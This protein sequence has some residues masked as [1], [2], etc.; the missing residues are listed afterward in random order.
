MCG[1]DSSVA[2]NRENV[3]TGQTFFCFPKISSKKALSS[4]EPT[5]LLLQPRLMLPKKHI[6]KPAIK[7]GKY[8]RGKGSKQNIARKRHLR[9]KHT[10]KQHC[11]Q[12]AQN[13]TN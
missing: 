5:K 12:Y 4:K 1:V 10:F 11:Y 6:V 13:N 2:E 7:Y 8:Y 3:R 9:I